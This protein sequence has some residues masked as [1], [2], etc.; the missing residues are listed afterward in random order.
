MCLCS[1]AGVR[2]HGHRIP[3]SASYH[4]SKV[5]FWNIYINILKKINNCTVCKTAEQLIQLYVFVFWVGQIRTTIWLNNLTLFSILS[6]GNFAVYL[7]WMRCVCVCYVGVCLFLSVW[8]HVTDMMGCV[9]NWS[10]SV[11]GQ[12]RQIT[13]CNY[14]EDTVTSLL[15]WRSVSP[16]SSHIQSLFLFKKILPIYSPQMSYEQ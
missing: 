5:H 8:T 2:P 11:T 10:N 9:A 13:A 7:S 4:F 15:A 16:L 3:N 12:E 1:L 6:Y 14:T